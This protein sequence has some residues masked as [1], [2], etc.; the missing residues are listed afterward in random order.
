MQRVHWFKGTWLLI[1]CLGRVILFGDCL[2][3]KETVLSRSRLLPGGVL[4][5]M[6]DHWVCLRLHSQPNVGHLKGYPSSRASSGAAKAVLGSPSQLDFSLRPILLP[7]PSRYGSQEHCPFT[8]SSPS[9]SL[10][11]GEPNLQ[12]L[13]LSPGVIILE[14][15]PTAVSLSPGTVLQDL[16]KW[17]NHT[18]TQKSTEQ[19]VKA[20]PRWTSLQRPSKSCLSWEHMSPSCHRG[21][22]KSRHWLI[23]MDPRWPEWRYKSSNS[24]FPNS[25]H[26]SYLGSW[27]LPGQDGEQG[28]F[29]FSIKRGHGEKDVKRFASSSTRKWMWKARK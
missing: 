9:Q 4:H 20:T 1:Q 19:S 11:P 10:L 25:K 13:L 8:S 2:E 5:P 16:S 6:A 28:L 21:F 15:Q 18:H 14:C 27:S 24:P 3:L 29:L 22:S 7:P 23:H 17:I 12:Q 26:L